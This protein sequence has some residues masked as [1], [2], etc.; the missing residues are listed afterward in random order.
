MQVAWQVRWSQAAT[1]AATATTSD[2]F[3]LHQLQ[4]RAMVYTGLPLGLYIIHP[5]MLENAFQT[6]NQMVKYRWSHDTR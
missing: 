3:P 1:V 6:D 2:A 4:A 5:S